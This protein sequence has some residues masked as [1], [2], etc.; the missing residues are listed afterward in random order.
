MQVIVDGGMLLSHR[1][2][3]GSG[4]S[5]AGLLIGEGWIETVS[6]AASVGGRIDDPCQIRRTRECFLG[7][8]KNCRTRHFSGPN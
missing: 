7:A 1:L 3:C 8:N 2:P 5:A 6:Q 4:S